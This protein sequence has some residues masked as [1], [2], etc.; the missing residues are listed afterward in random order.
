VYTRI[1][2]VYKGRRNFVHK[3]IA[4]TLWRVEYGKDVTSI[5]GVMLVDLHAIMQGH[6]L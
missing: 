5:T 3:G 6:F 2:L 4:S 1:F